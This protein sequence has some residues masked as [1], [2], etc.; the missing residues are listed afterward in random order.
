MCVCVCV[1]CGVK[2]GLPLHQQCKHQWT[3][4]RKK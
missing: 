4:Y 3:K 1:L 2:I